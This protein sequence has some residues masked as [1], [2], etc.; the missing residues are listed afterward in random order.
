MLYRMLVVEDDPAQAQI[1]SALLKGHFSANVE[2]EPSAAAAILRLEDAK[3]ARPD[4]MLLDL[5]LQEMSGFDVL[6]KITPLLSD[7]PVIILTAYGDVGSAVQALKLGAVDFIQ[8][9]EPKERV[10]TAIRNALEASHLRKEV[11]RLLAGH[12]NGDGFAEILGTSPALQR[13]LAL[14]RKASQSDIT[15]LLRGESGVGKERFARAIHTESDRRSQPF[16]AVNCGA[17]PENLVESTLFGHEKGS[18]TGAVNSSIGKFRAAEGGTIFLDEISELSLSAQ[19]KLLRVLQE[20]EVEPVGANKPVKIN[21]RVIAASNRDLKDAIAHKRFR[22][23]LYY[24]LTTFPITLPTLKER[25]AEDILLLAHHF[26][27][28]SVAEE[29]SVVVGFTPSVKNLLKAYGW[30]GNIR[31][32]ENSIRRAVLLCD[33]T[34]L[35][36]GDFPGLMAQPESNSEA[37]LPPAAKSRV[38]LTGANGHFRT[39]ADIEAEVLRAALQHYNWHISE[40]A[41]Q[42]GVGRSTLYRRIEALGLDA[43]RPK[44]APPLHAG[45]FPQPYTI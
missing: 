1:L 16:I 17:L 31:Q 44:D 19:T 2:I 36:T 21:V 5:R 8:K 41:R 33:D 11:R 35:D 43:E 22:E 45:M 18:F 23:D 29:H 12:G 30:P 24:R 42:L 7:L 38:A 10:L 40:A 25:G 3:K 20:K 15:V 28:C 34:M 26:L 4:I 9:Q 39:L 37:V 27:K 6:R 14:A 13:S 32:L